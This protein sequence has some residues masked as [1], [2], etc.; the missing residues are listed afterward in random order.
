MTTFCMTMTEEDRPSK[1]QRKREMEALKDLATRLV[2]VPGDHLDRLDDAEIRDAVLAARKITKGNARK[3]QVQYIAKLLSKTDATAAR[4]IIDS[5]DASSAAYVQRFHQLE[6]W[7]EQL[8]SG[9]RAAMDEVL[10][11]YPHADRQQLHTLV[12][13]AIRERESG[14]MVVYR[15]LFQFLKQLQEQDAEF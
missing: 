3:R 14:G 11:A 6:T 9:D 7:R 8:V 5:L 2:E 1:T 12:R 10:N 13:Q 15:K 4:D